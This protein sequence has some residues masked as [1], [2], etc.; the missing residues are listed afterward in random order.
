[1]P[2]STG[3]KHTRL[4]DDLKT[5]LVAVAPNIAFDVIWEVDPNFTWDGDGPDPV[6]DQGIFP[7]DVEVRAMAIL[8]GELKVGSDYLGGCYGEWDSADAEI[9]GYLN[10]MLEEALDELLK[11][12]PAT[13]PVSPLLR[14]YLDAKNAISERSKRQYDEQQKNKK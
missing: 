8:D 3:T 5:A 2:H 10:Q 6:E 13:V 4:P 9:G 14:Q 1:M 12:I 7:H 11:L